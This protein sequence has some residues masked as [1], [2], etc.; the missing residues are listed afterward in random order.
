[1]VKCQ[2]EKVLFSYLQLL[3]SRPLINVISGSEEGCP[4]HF[5]LHIR[6]LKNI[7]L[8]DLFFLL[9]LV[10]VVF[11]SI[12]LFLT[13]FILLLIIFLFFFFSYISMFSTHASSKIPS[14]SLSTFF[15]SSFPRCLLVRLPL[16]HNLHNHLNCVPLLLPI[17]HLH[18][19]PHIRRLKNHLS[20]CLL[21]YPSSCPS[22]LSLCLPLSHNL[23]PPLNYV[24]L[25]LPILYLHVFPHICPLKNILLFV[26]FFVLLLVLIVFLSVSL[27]LTT[28]ILFL[29][30]FLF[31]SLSYISM[32]FH[33]Y[34][35]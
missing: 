32:F 15:L 10:L 6:P 33:T 19:F 9:L 31:F 29:I 26:F 20:V 3:L 34:A 8:F 4:Y 17:L 22:F 12:S 5:L 2:N 13:T 24:P 1:M 11:L 30:V 21:L 14:F 18:V 16:S 35:L 7:L 25:F 28:F 27:L 23:H